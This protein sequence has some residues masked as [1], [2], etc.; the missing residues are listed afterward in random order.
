M[1][2]QVVRWRQRDVRDVL[3][4]RDGRQEPRLPPQAEPPGPRRLPQPRL[5]LRLA[6]PQRRREGPHPLLLEVRGRA[7]EWRSHAETWR[8]EEKFPWVCVHQSKG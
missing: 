4:V 2:L 5:H 3:R 8:Q 1:L 7:G 6:R